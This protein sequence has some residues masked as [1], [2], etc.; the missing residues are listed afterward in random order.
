MIFIH[1]KNSLLKFL[2]FLP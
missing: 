1:F 2:A